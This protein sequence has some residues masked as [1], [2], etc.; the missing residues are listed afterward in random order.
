MVEWSGV[1]TVFGSNTC[2]VSKQYRS[3][4]IVFFTGEA[5]RH[6]AGKTVVGSLLP[7]PSL[8]IALPHS[9]PSANR[10]IF[11]FLSRAAVLNSTL[12]YYADLR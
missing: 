7:L 10:I 5:R 8:G 2:S 3:A 6:C 9:N 11:L 4:L 12:R 1:K